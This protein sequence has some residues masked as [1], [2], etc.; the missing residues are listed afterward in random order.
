MKAASRRWHECMARA[1]SMRFSGVGTAADGRTIDLVITNVT[2][3]K[4][5]AGIPDAWF[6]RVTGTGL[7]EINLD[8]PRED[9][10]VDHTSVALKFTFVDQVRSALMCPRPTGRLLGRPRAK[11]RAC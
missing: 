2:A 8:S 1:M 10:G 11:S 9:A 3:Y 7:S 5:K 6:N 4:P